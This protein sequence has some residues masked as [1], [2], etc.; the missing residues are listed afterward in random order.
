MSKFCPYLQKIYQKFKVIQQERRK[1][2]LCFAFCT[3]WFQSTQN[4]FIFIT[5][6]TRIFPVCLRHTCRRFRRLGTI[7]FVNRSA[8][9]VLIFVSNWFFCC[10]TRFRRFLWNFFLRSNFFFDFSLRFNITRLLSF[11]ASFM[12][13]RIGFL[14]LFVY[15]D[16]SYVQNIFFWFP[17]A[18]LLT[19]AFP[20]YK[21]FDF[22]L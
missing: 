15:V 8:L 11:W 7:T 9:S 2:Y 3:G 19:P 22:T 5:A 16:K 12:W 6:T 10:R 13:C 20:F 1:Y 21:V 18:V 17:C 14:A 4:R